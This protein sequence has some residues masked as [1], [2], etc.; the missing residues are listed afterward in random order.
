MLLKLRDQ[1]KI[2]LSDQIAKFIPTLKDSRW[3]K[4]TI[5]DL[6]TMRS[7]LPTDDPWGDRLLPYSDQELSRVY[8][9]DL[10]FAADC[11]SEFHY[12]NLGYM[13]LGRIIS[14]VSGVS[15]LSAIKEQLL[16]PLAMHRTEWIPTGKEWLPGFTLKDSNF[17]KQ[18]IDQAIGDGAVFGGLWSTLNDLSIWLAFLMD[19]NQHQAARYQEVL[20]LASRQELQQGV[21]R[22]SPPKSIAVLTEGFD[23]ALGLRTFINRELTFVGHTGGLPGYGSHFRWHQETKLGIIALANLT[24]ASVYKPCQEALRIAVLNQQASCKPIAT[25]VKER[26]QQL[27]EYFHQ[28]SLDKN[29]ELF[30]FN[31][32]MDNPLGGFQ[33]EFAEIS[34]SFAAI[35]FSDLIVLPEPGLGAR[36]AVGG[37]FVFSFSLS[38]GEGGKVQEVVKFY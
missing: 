1:N 5:F 28:G 30:A 29:E 22:V 2:K 17:V 15:A 6:L 9:E 4:A 32:F 19:A 27:F 25:L 7:G 21:V 33:V 31:F 3:T 13:L 26:A 10:I 14:T 16:T 18:P 11:G 23:Y 8:S 20:S 12:S 38:P 35:S 37:E 34:K 36:V 24:Y